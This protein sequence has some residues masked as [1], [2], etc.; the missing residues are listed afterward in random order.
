MF[1]L[2]ITTINLTVNVFQDSNILTKFALDGIPFGIYKS[3]MV[4]FKYLVNGLNY[5][6]NQIKRDL[7][8]CRLTHMEHNRFHHFVSTFPATISE[9]HS[10]IQYIKY[11]ITL[12]TFK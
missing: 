1:N 4:K 3:K 9:S 8:S 6:C 11:N 12:P 7:I 5:N 10:L 2:F